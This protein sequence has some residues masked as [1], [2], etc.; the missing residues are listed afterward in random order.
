[1]TP[2]PTQ[3]VCPFCGETYQ[4][5]VAN[6]ADGTQWAEVLPCCLEA[7]DHWA[8]LYAGSLGQEIAV[9]LGVLGVREIYEDGLLRFPLINAVV[10]GS[11]QGVVFEFIQKH[12]RHHRKP[13]GWKFGA[14]AECG[15]VLVGVA[16]VGRPVSR[17]IQAAEP[18]TWEVTRV[19]TAG[20]RR[21]RYNA[22][23]ALYGACAREARRRG[24]RK[25]ITY[26]LESELGTSLRAAGWVEV[27][28]TKGGSWSNPSRPR[29]DKAPTCRKVRWEKAL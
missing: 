6:Q 1:M 29:T 16:V 17:V 28:R 26:T 23:S 19:C 21:L 11:W 18:A 5:D 2:E 3:P 8:E 22:S 4:L 7:R 20:D 14:V 25:L 24:Q 13:V 12:H 10:T 15:R 27:A 9:Q